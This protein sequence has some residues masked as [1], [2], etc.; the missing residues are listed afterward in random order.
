MAL[1]WRRG[2]SAQFRSRLRR[3]VKGIRKGALAFSDSDPG[4]PHGVALSG[5]GTLINE[6]PA[7]LSF[8]AQPVGTS[9]APQSTILTNTGSTAVSFYNVSITGANAGDFSLSNGCGKALAGGTSCSISV[10]FTPHGG[11]REKGGAKY[12]GDGRRQ[13]A[14]IPLSGT[15]S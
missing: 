15:G 8:V 14:L 5:I 6:A 4:S 1:A 3:Q 10:I 12:W 2:T 7:T 13:S 11:G 9:S